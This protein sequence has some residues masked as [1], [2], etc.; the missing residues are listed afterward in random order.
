MISALTEGN[1]SFILK[2]APSTVLTFS[3]LPAW[4]EMMCLLN[5][6]PS[7]IPDFLDPL[8]S[9]NNSLLRS[10]EIPS[11]LSYISMTMK[12][13][14]DVADSWMILDFLFEEVRE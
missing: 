6:R 8:K 5:Q 13:E 10:F 3:M 11:P 1:G 4:C 2:S 14:S 9:S 7:P 12:D